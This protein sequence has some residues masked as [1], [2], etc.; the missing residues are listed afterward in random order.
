M[1]QLIV[2][3]PFVEITAHARETL[4]RETQGN[5][6]RNECFAFL[7]MIVRIIWIDACKEIVE[8]GIIGL[9]LQLVVTA[10]DDSSSNYV[11]GILL[12]FSV[13]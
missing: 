9:H 13:E 8:I 3:A 5:G 2:A 11:A 7:Q 12:T 6:W 4:L 10:I 1:S